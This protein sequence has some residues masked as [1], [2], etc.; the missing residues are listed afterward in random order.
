MVGAGARRLPAGRKTIRGE[1]TQHADHR[2]VEA[3]S[4]GVAAAGA[5]AAYQRGTD[6]ERGVEPGDQIADRR[7]GAQRRAVGLA[8]D[9]R[10][11]AH[12][13]GDEIE[14]GT[15]A[16]RPAV[17]EAGDVTTD[18]VGVQYFE[19]YRVESDAGENPGTEILDQHIAAGDQLRQ[20]QAP[21]VMPQV[22]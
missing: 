16:I 3:G 11:A 7:T 8:G 21:L 14:R 4:D 18:E 9:A 17:A 20:H 22:E 13:L 5:A 12:R 15:V 1:K 6:P 19:P 2:V 10:E